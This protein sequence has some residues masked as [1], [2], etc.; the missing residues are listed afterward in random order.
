MEAW[1]RTWGQEG[2][3]E[4][5]LSSIRLNSMKLVFYKKKPIDNWQFLHGSS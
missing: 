3:E 5:D 4:M 2:G 1:T